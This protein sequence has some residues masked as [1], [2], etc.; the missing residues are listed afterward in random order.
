MKK[1]TKILL[2]MLLVFCMMLGA[3]DSTL[4]NE[5]GTTGTSQTQGKTEAT[6]AGTTGTTSET[7]EAHVCSFEKVTSSEYLVNAGNCQTAPT[8]KSVC[9]C[10]ALGEEYSL[11][12]KLPH[13]DSNGNFVCDTCHV[14]MG[15]LDCVAT[16]FN[17]KDGRKAI[18]TMSFD[19]GHYDTAVLLNELLEEYDLYA[20]LMMISD[21]I[22]NSTAWKKIFAEGRLE[23]QSHSSSHKVIAPPSY[24][25]YNPNNNT[26]QVIQYE[27]VNSRDRLEKMFS[28]YD[29][30]VFAI[31]NSITIPES[32]KAIMETYYAARSG[33]LGNAKKN[34]VQS[35]NPTVG[36]AKPGGWYNPYIT[37]FRFNSGHET[38]QG[39]IEYLDVCVENGGWF[40]SLC[41]ALVNDGTAHCDMS[42]AHA[43]QL[44][45]VM[46]QYSEEGK[47]WCTTYGDAVKYVRERQ[48]S[49]A[50]QYINENGIFV[51]LT[52]SE[53]TEDGLP[54]PADVF[55]MPLT[56]KI[57]VPTGWTKVKYTQGDV[58]AVVDTYVENN[59]TYANINIVP[60]GADAAITNGAQ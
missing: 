34:I 50:E 60:N 47:I 16:I 24:S 51:K 30:L 49:T 13:A 12:T 27:I 58:S 37:R 41:H 21:N 6:T 45:A 36:S 57:A 15:T 14:Q 20:S 18:V 40:I 28:N 52:M 11:D 25:A 1:I 17:V 32:E 43:R 42:E 35:L 53:K 56:V 44:F 23:P 59:K 9:R 5:E 55:D 3:C 19:D 10:G 31:P 38:L 8:Y 26:P 48:N 54:L 46:Q 4:G 2:C 7:E 29:C 33:Q 22:G 39:A